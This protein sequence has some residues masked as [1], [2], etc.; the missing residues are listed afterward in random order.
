MFSSDVTTGLIR[1][2]SEGFLYKPGRKEVETVEEQV[3]TSVQSL[4][5]VLSPCF[6]FYD[7]SLPTFISVFST[8]LCLP[9]S[10]S[11]KLPY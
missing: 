8:S 6:H 11:F 7:L 3:L 10:F 4:L 2:E 1:A 5:S 9:I